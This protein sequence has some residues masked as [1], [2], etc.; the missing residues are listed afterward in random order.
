MV[1][2]Y[3]TSRM[4]A[5]DMKISTIGIDLA[6]EVFQIHAADQSGKVVQR[7]KL[8]RSEMLTYFANLETCL[9]GMEACSSAHYW[10]RKLVAMGHTVK[11]MAPQFVKPYVKANKNDA[12]DAEAI[13]EAVTRPTMRF[14][15][16][17]NLD[18]QTI[19][20]THRVRQLLV[21]Q[22]TARANQIRGLLSEFGVVIPRGIHFLGV[23]IPEILEDAENELTPGMRTL[24][25]DCYESLKS[26]TDEID[27]HE[28]TIKS[29]HKQNALSK[30]LERIPGVGPLT[31]TAFLATIGDAMEFKSG[32]EL[33]AFLGLVP[34]QS[35]S[36]GKQNLLGISK[37]GDSYLRTLL[38]HGARS[39]V[40]VVESNPPNH[41]W[42]DS[43]I[44][45]RNKN[46][47][48][49]A[50]ANKNVRTIW[51]LLTKDRE[52][53]PEYISVSSVSFTA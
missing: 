22:R 4:G 28:Q 20:A 18:Q 50:L 43:L 6:K 48:A 14:V 29:F 35:S 13:C 38:I 44:G 27:R 25:H 16:I 37:R 49:V 2:H 19:L 3:F 17:K 10:A 42:L 23:R 34:R 40:R 11:L 45:R 21:V 12:A 36:G 9:I 47:A 26:L 1:M 41:I 5:S 24:I 32:R 51:A 30:R 39:V 52:F 53:D 33:S 7:K 15:S 31:A 46:V 8:R